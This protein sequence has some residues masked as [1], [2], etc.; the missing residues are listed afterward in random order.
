M[1]RLPFLALL[2]PFAACGP[3]AIPDI[4]TFEIGGGGARFMTDAKTPF[5]AY[6]KAYSELTKQHLGLRREIGPNGNRFALESYSARIVRNLQIMKS[7][8]VT[9]A[10][11]TLDPYLKFYIEVHDLA[12]SGRLGGNY[13]NLL[14][15]YEREI[16]VNY[17]PD[18]VHI[19]AE[20]EK[21]AKDAKTEET[22]QGA[23]V[24][25]EEK[26]DDL[27][28]PVEKKEEDLRPKIETPIETPVE[29]PVKDES[30]GY[31][32]MYKAW[33]KSHDEL[34]AAFQIRKDAK[35]R[36]DEVREALRELAKRLDAKQADRL[37]VY[38]AFYE[39]ILEDTRGFT[40]L[41]EG[42]KD[43]DVL[44]DLKIVAA[45]VAKD[46]DPARRK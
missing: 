2:L 21:S 38:V 33:L 22:A 39:K 5:E 14:N 43:E 28:P 35:A 8:L 37:Q 19:A 32:L 9:P 6:D 18:N 4:P 7:V 16:H 24:K 45:G 27:P 41:P 13:V 40:T 1:K 44:N 30:I 15:Q 10:P 46:F 17:A 42:T 26:T 25:K 31:R 20:F 36:Y 29:T 34:C 11:S 12:K 3:D 23:K